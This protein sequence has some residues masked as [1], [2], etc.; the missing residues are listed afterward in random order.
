[1]QK[2]VFDNQEK[3]VKDVVLITDGEDQDSFAVQAAEALGK[4]SVRRMAVGLGDEVSGTPILVTGE[5]GSRDFI[6]NKGEVV[7]SKLDGATLREMVAATPG[8]R[9][10]PVATGNF[11]LG[12]IY[13]S[14]IT[15]AEKRLVESETVE[16]YEEKYQI[17]LFAALLLLMIEPF[18][19]IRRA[20]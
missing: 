13:R 18:V 12:A 8:G 14:L 9:Y 5:D 10:L 11:D 19:G 6:K 16:R 20:A 2:E 1:M 17:F 15:T 7:R 3:Q 4:A